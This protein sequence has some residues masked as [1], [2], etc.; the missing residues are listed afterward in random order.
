MLDFLKELSQARL[1]TVFV[2]SGLAFFA[3]AVLGNIS[4]TIQPG[5]AGRVTAGVLAPGLIGLGLWMHAGHVAENR[6]A[7]NAAADTN[8]GKR[9]DS[10][11]AV[12]PAQ[13]ESHPPN[14]GNPNDSSLTS[15]PLSY[16]D[17]H[18]RNVNR[19]SGGITTLDIR[20]VDGRVLVHTWGKCEPTDCDWGEV[21]SEPFAPNV[22]SRDV[23]S[24]AI[25]HKFQRD[26]I[27]DPPPNGGHARS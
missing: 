6:A 22:S 17:G 23:R 7:E 12:V 20:G 9:D 25:P 13:T 26:D 18:W 15:V 11:A 4:G 8:S 16:F 5:K 2:L 21:E 14:P 27:D 3:V 1:D 19:D 24:I 10:A